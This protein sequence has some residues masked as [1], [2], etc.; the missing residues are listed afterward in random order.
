MALYEEIVCTSCFWVKCKKK[1]TPHVI[2]TSPFNKEIDPF[3]MSS[4]YTYI[5]NF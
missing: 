4:K 2:L 1:K 5:I 3:I